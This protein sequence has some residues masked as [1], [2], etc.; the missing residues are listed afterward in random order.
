MQHSRSS[1]TIATGLAMFSMF[2]GAGNVVFP[3]VLGRISQD[4]NI[5]A[6]I[7]LLLTAVGVPFTG[8]IAMTL[9]DGDY[10][11]FFGRIGKT[12]GFIVSILIMALIG[13]LGALPR[14]IALAYSTAEI[15]LPGISIVTFS[16]LSCVV[17]FLFTFRRNNIIEVLGY[18]LTPFLLLSLGIIIVKGIYDAPALPHSAH[19][20]IQAFLHGLKDGYLTMDLL[21]A[22]FFSSVVLVCL[23]QQASSAEETTPRSLVKLTLKA[24]CFGAFLL[25]LIYAGFSYAAAYHSLALEGVS[26]D[27]LINAMSVHILGPYAGLIVCVAV[28]LACLTTAIAL[29]AVFAEFLYEDISQFKL[30]YISSLIITLVVTAFVATFNF[31]SIVSFLAPILQAIYPALI[32]L[33]LTNIFYKLYD[34]KPVKTPFFLTLAITVAALVLRG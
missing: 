29:A 1:N 15:Y 28:A 7:G 11:T 13:P 20:P 26:S 17:I 25:A 32:V 33:S 4:N 2:F 6:I 12:P 22:F 18:V 16:I 14:C 3:L 10:K 31:S 27:A 19:E 24:S 21:G 30:G 34:F 9:F 23:R 8:L 5:Y